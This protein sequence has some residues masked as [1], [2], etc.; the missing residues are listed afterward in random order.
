ME[1]ISSSMKKD[2]LK[3]LNILYLI[4]SLLIAILKHIQVSETCHAIQTD[5]EMDVFDYQILQRR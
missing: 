2:S 1:A 5:I 4:C 3:R